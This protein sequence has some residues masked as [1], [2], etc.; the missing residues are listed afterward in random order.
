[1]KTTVHRQIHKSIHFLKQYL[2]AYVSVRDN[3][4]NDY[5][6]VI[7]KIPR[8]IFFFWNSRLLSNPC[9]NTQTNTTNRCFIMINN[10]SSVN[11]KK[12][13]ICDKYVK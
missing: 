9:Q 3:I 11:Y 12:V 4:K 2:S 5:C 10:A 1:M 13:V 7:K 6:V 8:S